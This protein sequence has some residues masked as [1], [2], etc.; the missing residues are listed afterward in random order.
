MKKHSADHYKEKL[1]QE[2]FK[3]TPQRLEV[4]RALLELDH[5]TAKSVRAE[6]ERREK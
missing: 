5:P 3:V 6:I 1:K 2:G 4:I